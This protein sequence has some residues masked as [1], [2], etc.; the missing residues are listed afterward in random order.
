MRPETEFFLQNS[1]SQSLLAL[2]FAMSFAVLHISILGD[3]YKLQCILAYSDCGCKPKSPVNRE[4][5]WLAVRE[6]REG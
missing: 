5:A 2:S 4:K 3:N 1:V 6:G